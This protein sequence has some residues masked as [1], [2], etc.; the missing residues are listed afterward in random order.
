SAIRNPQSGLPNPQSAICNPQSRRSF[1]ADMGMGFTGLALSAM[2]AREQGVHANAPAAWAPPD[3]RPHFTPRAKSVICLFTVGGTSHL[4][5]FDPKPE[6]NRWAGKT[7][8]ETPYGA[9]L[10]S[11]YLRRNLR[12]V[13]PITHSH[14][15]PMQVGYRQRGQSGIAIT[16]WWPHLGDCVDDMA[17]IRSMWTTDNNHGAQLQFFTGRHLLDGVFPTVGSWVHYGLGTL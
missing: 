1:L 11:P 13:P 3:G 15:L 14:I 6:L 5:S 7:F 4:E 17:I 16:D 2:L 10:E 9:V 8:Q 12:V